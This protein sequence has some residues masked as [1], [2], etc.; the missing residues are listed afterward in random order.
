LTSALPWRNRW[1]SS[2]GPSVSAICTAISDV[3]FGP[4]R[5]SGLAM[6]TTRRLYCAA[7]FDPDSA[8]P[9]A[10]HTVGPATL[11]IVVSSI[12]PAV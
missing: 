1:A 4:S 12:A 5:S 2:N 7:A 11:S 6:P 3:S 9:P 8:V 10:T